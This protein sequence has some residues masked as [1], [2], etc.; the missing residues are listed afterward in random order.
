[1]HVGCCECQH[2]TA[3]DHCERCMP[4]F[5]GSATDGTPHDCQPCPCPPAS[6]CV[7]LL[8]GQVVCTDCPAGHTGLPVELLRF[9]RSL[10]VVLFF[11]Y[12]KVNCFTGYARVKS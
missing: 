7:Q 6:N 12:R 5:Y 8:D 3:G 2:N 10:T 1:M 9:D 4:G 11:F